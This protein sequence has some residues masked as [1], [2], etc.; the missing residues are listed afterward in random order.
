MSQH[1]RILN[2]LFT[3]RHPSRHESAHSK[4]LEDLGYHVP[5]AELTALINQLDIDKSGRPYP[6][7]AS[8]H[9]MRGHVVSRND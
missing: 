6:F 1:N 9:S 5:E 2:T 8:R 4:V 7:A 3:T